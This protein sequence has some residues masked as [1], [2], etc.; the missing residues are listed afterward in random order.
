MKN[1]SILFG[2]LAFV[3]AISAA[4]AS[5]SSTDD[6][7]GWIQIDENSS[8]CESSITCNNQPGVPCK[9]NN[10]QLYEKAG[11]QCSTALSRSNP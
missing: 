10:I 9:V 5:Q 11:S 4:F 7:Q 3:I 2:L 8:A 1:R 6:V